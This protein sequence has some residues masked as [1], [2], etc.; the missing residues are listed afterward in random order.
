[1]FFAN[2]FISA[3][4][5]IFIIPEIKKE[6]L[7]QKH[8]F[9]SYSKS[10]SFGF[11]NIYMFMFDNSGEQNARHDGEKKTIMLVGAT[12][13]GKSTLV[14]GFINYVIGV[15]WNDPFRFTVNDAPKD[16]GNINKVK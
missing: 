6:R 16:N 8:T 5:Q 1:V 11:Y 2:R 10:Y 3:K 13:S 9:N 4:I 7:T 15:N 14:D 12:G